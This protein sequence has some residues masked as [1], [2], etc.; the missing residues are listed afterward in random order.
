M[1]IEDIAANLRK[2]MIYCIMGIVT[3]NIAT[4]SYREVAMDSRLEAKCS[5]KLAHQEVSPDSIASSAN[6][7]YHIWNYKTLILP[8]QNP[9]PPQL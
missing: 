8:S 6:K 5:V 1:Q 9:S 7:L 3:Q 2:C 4:V